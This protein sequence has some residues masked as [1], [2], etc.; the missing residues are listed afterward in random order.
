[1]PDPALNLWR[2]EDA[3]AALRPSGLAARLGSNS[4]SERCVGRRNCPQ[5]RRGS[6]TVVTSPRGDDALAS[7]G[8]PAAHAGEAASRSAGD[9]V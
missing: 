9:G 6:A 4:K 8:P 1:M 7:A 3:V 5:R 2:S